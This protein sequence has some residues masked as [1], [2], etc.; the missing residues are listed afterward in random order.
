MNNQVST[1]MFAEDMLKFIEQCPTPYHAVE[2]LASLFLEEGFVEAKGAFPLAPF[3]TRRSPGVFLAVRPGKKSLSVSG[4]R[5][6]LAHLDSPCL[7]IKEHPDGY[8]G[9]SRL[10][11]SAY[12][13][14]NKE[15]F[16]NIPL[17]IAGQAMVLEDGM[18]RRKSFLLVDTVVIPSLATHLRNEK[19][20]V[21]VQEGMQ[22]VWS[23]KKKRFIASV[24]DALS[25]REEELWALEAYAVVCDQG[26]V[27]S[28]PV[29]L[30][31][32][33][34]LDDL[35]MVYV[36]MQALFHSEQADETQALMFF[37][38]EEVGSLSREGAF[39]PL[40]SHTLEQMVLAQDKSR[41]AYHRA[42]ERSHLVSLDLAHGY[43]PGYAEKYDPDSTPRLGKGPALKLSS[44]GKYAMDLE[45]R[46]FLTYCAQQVGIPIQSYE[47]HSD[48]RG[49]ATMG[50]MASA[51]SLMPAVD[52]GVPILAM[53][54]ARELGCVD[55]FIFCER[56]MRAYLQEQTPGRTN[57]E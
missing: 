36:A 51:Y 3:F 21:T 52:I 32:S 41:E 19:D 48:I 54:A 20:E 24:C 57:I 50:P 30:I 46:A 42:M 35:S 40:L 2:T 4:V 9:L 29:D 26:T 11:V 7:R 27:M 6:L 18:L 1:L 12:G 34:R 53:H 55:D 56:W 22:V 39:S 47:V 44:Q 14:L 25:I 37:N 17:K 28:S 23:S 45:Q 5:W 13:G 38:Q 49:G 8:E 10:R 33:P 31:L 15:S 16:Q 43:H